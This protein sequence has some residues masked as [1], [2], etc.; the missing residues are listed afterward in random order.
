M[1][2]FNHLAKVLILYESVFYKSWYG[3]VNNVLGGMNAPLLCRSSMQGRFHL[4]LDSSILMT[5]KEAK[6]LHALGLKVPQ[7]TLGLI[8]QEDQMTILISK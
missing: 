6:Y 7:T 8:Q 2:R 3:E 4:N 5:I 1:K